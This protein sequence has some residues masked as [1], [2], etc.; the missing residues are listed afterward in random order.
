MRQPDDWCETD[1]QIIQ[2][3]DEVDKQAEQL[4]LLQ[5]DNKLLREALIEQTGAWCDLVNSG[6]AGNWNPEDDDEVIKSRKALA[7]TKKDNQ[8]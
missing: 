4:K 3:S 8:K 6:D 1:V 5:A 7:A 2:L